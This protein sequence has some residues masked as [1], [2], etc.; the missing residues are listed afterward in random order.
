LPEINPLSGFEEFRRFF[1]FTIA[2]PFIGLIVVGFASV[3]LYRPWC[4]FLCPFGA[5]SCFCSNF[6]SV[7]I[8]VQKIVQNVGCVKRFAQLKKLFPIVKMESAI[9]AIVALKFAPKML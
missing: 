3:F 2:F 8:Y 4:R 5:V 9:I 6:A 7:F 1:A